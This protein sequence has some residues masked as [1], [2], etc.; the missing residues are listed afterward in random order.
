MDM[1]A[2]N[3]RRETPLF[4]ASSN[5]H[6]EVVKVLLKQGSI[7][8]DI[9]DVWCWTPLQKATA[10]GLERIVELLLDHGAYVETQSKRG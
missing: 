8:V 2:E 9:Q 4:L 3:A 7:S 5:G 10:N 1:R 6:E